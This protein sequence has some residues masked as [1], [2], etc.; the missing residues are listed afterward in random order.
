MRSAD[1]LLRR[2]SELQAEAGEVARE[3]QLTERLST[4]G[5]PV[6]V[7][8]AALGLMVGRDL[9]ITVVCR[10]LGAV[11]EAVA[12]TGAWLAIHP[13]VRRVEFRDDTGH[14]NTDPAYPDGLYLKVEYR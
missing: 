5:E 14:W 8:S 12:R 9:D 2:Q 3:L 1:D 10:E 13:R 4:V 7:G 6:R 11:T